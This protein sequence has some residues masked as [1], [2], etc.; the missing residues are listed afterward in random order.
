MTPDGNVDTLFS[1][2]GTNGEGPN[3][4]LQGSDGSLYGTTIFGGSGFN[5]TLTSGDGAVFRITTNG[6]F[7]L[8]AS[9]DHTTSGARPAGKLLEMSNGVF[10]GTADVGGSDIP[11]GNNSFGT[12][13]EVTTNGLTVLLRFYV[14]LPCYLAGGVIKAT[15]GNYYGNAASGG[16]YAIRPIQAPVVQASLQDGQINLTWNA[17]TGYRYTVFT[18][19]NAAIPP[20][21]WNQY[22]PTDEYFDVNSFQAVATT[23]GP[24][25]FSDPIGPDLQRFYQVTMEN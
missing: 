22:W 9:L 15:D 18:Q 5:G 1:F 20:V 7:T 10:Y 6:D 23:N 8:L 25:T 21:Y 14:G 2:N 16:V 17:W 19:T 4:L 12:L 11:G 24:M 13:F 3:T